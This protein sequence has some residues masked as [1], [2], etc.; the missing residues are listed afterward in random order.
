MCYISFTDI[1]RIKKKKEN[2]LPKYIRNCFSGNLIYTGHFY[3]F[4]SQNYINNTFTSILDSA[5]LN[6][7]LFLN[8]FLTELYKTLCIFSSPLFV[9]FETGPLRRMLVFIIQTCYFSCFFN[10]SNGFSKC[11][12]CFSNF[13][14]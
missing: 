8:L 3:W 13:L 12:Y 6:I 10:N 5:Y 9:R 2:P 7:S 1:P 11:Q 4:E 14:L